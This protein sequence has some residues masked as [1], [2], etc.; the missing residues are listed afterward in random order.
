MLTY[1]QNSSPSKWG[2][3]LLWH[4]EAGSIAVILSTTLPRRRSRCGFSLSL[5]PWKGLGPPASGML[6]LR[7]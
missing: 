5:R 3:C 6:W 7:C 2:A 1:V 4:C